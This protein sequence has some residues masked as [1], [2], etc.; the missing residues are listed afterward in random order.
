MKTVLRTVI[1]L[2][3]VLAALS[4]LLPRH[5]HVERSVVMAAAPSAVFA[6]IND[7]SQFNKWS[8][9][10]QIDPATQYAFTGPTSGVGATM[11]WQSEHPHVGNGTQE[12]IESVP[13]E[14]VTT[15]LRFA[16]EGDATATIALAPEPNGTR[17]TWSFDSDLGLNPLSR[18]FG[19][20]LD[21]MIGS[22][23]EQGLATL[24][25]LAEAQDHR[26]PMTP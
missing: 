15:R 7:L 4:L 16:G 1:G 18:Y 25:S 24:K 19:L 5:A 14:H 26:H 11:T 23:Y 17:V 20:M 2:I 8:P 13:D 21:S 3:I 10:A 12:I 22:N 9:W 6:Y